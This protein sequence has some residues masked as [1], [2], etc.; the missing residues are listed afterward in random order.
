MEEQYHREG[1]LVVPFLQPNEL[2]TL[3]RLFEE[4]SSGCATGFY[5]SLWSGDIEYRRRVHEEIQRT[6]ARPIG[7]LLDNYRLCLAN[8]AVKHPGQS[9]SKVPVHQ[10]WSMVDESRH[11]TVSIWCPLVDVDSI[12]G[13][14]AV[15]P[16]SHRIINNIRANQ[17]HEA[18]YSPFGRIYERLEQA[19]LRELPMRAGEAVIYKQALLH[20]SRI[21]HSPTPRAAVVAA[22]LPREAQLRHYYQTSPTNIDV[23]D[24]A[25]DFYWK[26]V[27]LSL[28]PAGLLP[29]A[30]V[31]VVERHVT[32]EEVAA[33]LPEPPPLAGA[34]R[35]LPSGASVA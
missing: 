5:S 23:Y 21:N 27:R 1:F 2:E 29:V 28:P 24:V 11:F 31:S 16:R 14:L 12:N 19:Y 3:R 10:D 22:Y 8:F 9:D 33:M 20:G 15:V 4:A 17:P 7:Q 30:S 32:E 13:C 6:F 26:D 25:D 18:N 34:D 35:S